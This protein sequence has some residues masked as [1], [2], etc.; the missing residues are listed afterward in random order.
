M[1]LIPKDLLGTGDE[2]WVT[3]CKVGPFVGIGL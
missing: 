3:G 1:D 2:L